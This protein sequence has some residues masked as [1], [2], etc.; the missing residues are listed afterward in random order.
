MRTTSICCTKQGFPKGGAKISKGRSGIDFEICGDELI[1]DILELQMKSKQKV[2]SIYL[3]D[4]KTYTRH[5]RVANEK[6]I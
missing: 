3:G 6:K 2:F 5:S 1:L 4:F